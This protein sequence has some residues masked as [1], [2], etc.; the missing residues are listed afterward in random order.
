MRSLVLVWVWL[1]CF[2]SF[3]QNLRFGIMGSSAQLEPEITLQKLELGETSIDLRLAGNPQTGLEFGL[4]M[5]QNQFFGPLGNLAL[6]SSLELSTK[7]NYA[8][9]LAAEGVIASIAASLKGSLSNAPP[10]TFQSTSSFQNDS[11]VLLLTEGSLAGSLELKARYRLSRALIISADPSLFFTDDGPSLHLAASMLWPRL[12]DPDDAS[13]WLEGYLAPQGLG[14]AALG[15]GYD[16]NRRSLPALQAKIW[17]GLSDR[18]LFP[19]LQAEFRQRLQVLDASYGADLW[20]EPY[21]Q[22]LPVFRARAFYQQAIGYGTISA[23]ILSS[24]GGTLTPFMLGM[25]YQITLP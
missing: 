7:A 8:V 19:G 1:S 16:L 22:D 18:G 15:L 2:N 23:E 3:A 9:S 6:S 14:Y 20:L 17:L 24:S 5:K 10:G 13:L 25:S 21:R 12:F 4:F 11:R